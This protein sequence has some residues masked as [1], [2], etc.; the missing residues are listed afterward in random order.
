MQ[1]SPAGTGSPAS[2]KV[3]LPHVTLLNGPRPQASTAPPLSPAAPKADATKV[4]LVGLDDQGRPHAS[5]FDEEQA[6]AAAVAADLMGMALL[7]TRHQ[8]VADIAER[9]PKGKLFESGKAFLPYVKRPVYDQ[10]AVHLDEDYLVST[11]ARIEAAQAAAAEGYAKA[12][13]GE[14]PPRQPEDWSKLTVGDL[15]LAA[16]DPADG[17][18]DAEVLELLADDRLRLRWRDYADLPDFTRGIIEI[19]L[20]HPKFPAR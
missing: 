4:I 6:D 2:K 11:A 1:I 13:K 9:L 14:V 15:V 18:F 7:E 10:L 17:W 12:S 20:L 16:D 8:D 5:W 19:A 3:S